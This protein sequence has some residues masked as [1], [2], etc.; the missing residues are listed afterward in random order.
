MA[1]KFKM[2]SSE[3]MIPEA[4]DKHLT[5]EELDQQI[6]MYDAITYDEGVTPDQYVDKKEI[7]KESERKISAFKKEKI[8][9]SAFE[10]FFRLAS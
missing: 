5:E 9:K 4:T 2:G 8:G 6:D 1:E 3:F 7:S 10:T